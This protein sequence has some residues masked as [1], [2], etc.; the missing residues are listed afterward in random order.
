[1]IKGVPYMLFIEYV[2]EILGFLRIAISKR[3]FIVRGCPYNMFIMVL[4]ASNGDT[5]C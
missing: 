4:W 1:M 5:G 2:H 3:V